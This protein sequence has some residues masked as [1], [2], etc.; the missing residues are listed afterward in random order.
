VLIYSLSQ[1]LRGRGVE[2]Y[3]LRACPDGEGDW[4]NEA[5]PMLVRQIRIKGQWTPRWLQRIG[6]DIQ[7]RHL[8]LLV[9][10]G[11]RPTPEQ[12]ELFALCTHAV[13]LTPDDASQASWQALVARHR[14]PLLADLTS[15]LEGENRLEAA[16]P[17][18]RGA[19]ANL[20][21]GGTASGAAFDALVSRIAARFTADGVDYPR[22]HLASAP[23][24]IELVVDLE[25]LART[26]GWTQEG[27]TIHWLPEHLPALLEYLPAAA[28]LAIYPPGEPPGSRPLWRSW[29]AQPTITASTCGWGWVP[30][31]RLPLGNPPPDG[32]LRFELSALGDA[33]VV[34]GC[35]PE[36]YI[37]WSE[38]DQV[39]AP[40]VPPERGVVLSGRLALLALHQPGPRLPRR[41]LAGGAPTGAGR[42]RG[43]VFGG[44]SLAGGPCVARLIGGAVCSEVKNES[45]D[46]AGR[47]GRR[48]AESALQ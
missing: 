9:D 7:R 1:A 29:P 12:A 35:L 30:A 24:A 34:E 45:A 4:S 16:E 27:A 19:L 42:E 26:L 38:I 33:V 6:Q 40:P 48:S 18:L 25:R 14:L 46:S 2:H 8:P 43:G 15:T 32:P 5:P 10:V 20:Q 13:L 28:P 17:V 44:S 3:A 37:D 22:R 36:H 41:A 21:R 31:Q 11:G 39:V 47:A 23:A